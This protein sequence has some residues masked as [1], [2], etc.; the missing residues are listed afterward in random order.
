MNETSLW[1][2]I[3][4]Y[5]MTL[6]MYYRRGHVFPSCNQYMLFLIMCGLYVKKKCWFINCVLSESKYSFMVVDHCKIT[7]TY[8]HKNQLD[9]KL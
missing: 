2:D 4:V 6:D 7:S 1:F 8:S 3:F 9:M 5:H